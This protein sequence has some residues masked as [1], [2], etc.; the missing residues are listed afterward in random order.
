MAPKKGKAG[1]ASAALTALAGIAG[2]NV[3]SLVGGEDLASG[4]VALGESLGG[5]VPGATAATEALKAFTSGGKSVYEAMVKNAS[6]IE[7]YRIRLT[8]ATGAGSNFVAQLRSQAYDL[9]QYGVGLKNL[10]AANEAIAASYGKA[11]FGAATTRQEFEGE[12]KSLQLLVATN[13]KFGLSMSETVSFAS[14][15]RNTIAGNSTEINKYSDTLLMFAR[16]TGQTFSKVM[17]E[18]SSYSER[19][20]A[21]MD[22]ERATKTFTTLESLAKRAGTQVGTLVGS[23]SK[24]DDIDQSFSSGGQINRILSYFGGSFDTLAAASANEEELAEMLIQSL[25]DISG[26]FNRQI[27]DPKAKRALFK[28]LQSATG[29]PPE[30]IAGILNEKND[31]S[32]DLLNIVRTPAVTKVEAMSESDRK[33]MSLDL[34][35]QAEIGAIREENMY[36]GPLTM[37]LEKFINNQ[38]DVTLAASTKIGRAVDSVL[39]QVKTGNFTKALDAVATVLSESEKSFQGATDKFVSSLGAKGVQGVLNDVGD[40]FKRNVEKIDSDAVLARN[41]AAMQKVHAKA[42]AVEQQKR[43]EDRTQTAKA[44]K[45]G[46]AGVNYQVIVYVDAQGKVVKQEVRDSAGKAVTKGG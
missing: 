15:L 31:L 21:T 38:K 46:L 5:M 13:E 25:K 32:K 29:L 2:I 1:V 17:Q 26:T 40:T 42:D 27:T 7:D 20:M 35:K 19:F 43:N 3:S 39:K 6:V 33:K 45:D 18:F 37:A 24:F 28:D 4:A 23:L 30:M 11:T 44:I 10:V 9:N 8:N 12:R 14:R 41:E 36:I 16:G 22:P 34:T